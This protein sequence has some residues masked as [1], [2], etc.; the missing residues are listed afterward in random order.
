MAKAAALQINL[1]LAPL[2]PSAPPTVSARKSHAPL[3]HDLNL[4]HH[5]S[6]LP[7]IASNLLLV[8]TVAFIS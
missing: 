3:H 5:I 1:H 4:A 7:L 8:V 6:P 2:V